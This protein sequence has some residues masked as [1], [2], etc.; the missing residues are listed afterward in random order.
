[1]G[2]MTVYRLLDLFC[3]AGG[4]AMG[5]HLTGLFDVT[6]VDILPQPRYP[7]KFVQADAVQYLMDHGADYDIIHL[8]PPC[9]GYSVTRFLKHAKG[10]PDLI[11]LLRGTLKEIGKPYIIENVVGAPLENPIMLCGLMFGLR[12]FRHRLF[13]TSPMILGPY[14]PRHPKWAKA[15]GQGKYSSFATDGATI[16]TVFGNGFSMR[17]ASIAMGIDWMARRELSQAI[18][19]AYTHYIG[20]IIAN[21][22]AGGEKWDT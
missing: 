14:H 6:G 4:A 1:M 12:L 3:G 8:S 20:Q 18:P 19:P 2:Q 7:F 9:Q 11:P 15:A 5:Y 21:T 10:G 17:D 13:E 16:I 22:I